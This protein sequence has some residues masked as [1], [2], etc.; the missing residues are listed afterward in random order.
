MK[1]IATLLILCSAPWLLTGC[2]SSLTGDTYSRSEARVAQTVE[3][4]TVQDLRLVKIEG[5]KTPVGPAAG[6]ALGGLAGSSVGSGKTS[7]AAAIVGGLAGAF[8]GAAAEEGI[9]RSQGI[10]ITVRLDS[11]RIVAV[12]QQQDPSVVFQVGDRVQLHTTR[13]TTRVVK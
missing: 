9:T 3:Y 7:T 12:V 8:V 4:G 13:G 1:H 5:T 2:P 11:G 10:E 6:A